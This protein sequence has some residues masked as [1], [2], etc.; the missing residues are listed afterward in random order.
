MGGEQQVLDPGWV[1][2]GDVDL[3]QAQPPRGEL[4][5]VT[6]QPQGMLVGT[7]LNPTGEKA[8]Y[9]AADQACDRPAESTN[10]IAVGE[11]MEFTPARRSK[12]PHCP[13]R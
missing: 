3:G 11:P 6:G 10:P 12:A 2:V 8:L 13:N 4:G 5:G 9:R 1:D 7:G